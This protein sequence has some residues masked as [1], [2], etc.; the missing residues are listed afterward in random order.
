MPRRS[1]GV[2]WGVEARVGVGWGVL[3]SSMFD[4][5][6][7]LSSLAKLLTSSEHSLA[8]ASAWTHFWTQQRQRV[9]G[10]GGSGAGVP[11]GTHTLSVRVLHCTAW[12]KV[13]PYVCFV[14][15][16]GSPPPTTHHQSL[17]L[18]RCGIQPGSPGCWHRPHSGLGH[19][20]LAV[21]PL[22]PLRSLQAAISSEGYQGGCQLLW[23][24]EWIGGIWFGDV[25]WNRKLCHVFL[26]FFFSC[27]SCW[28]FFSPQYFR[29]RI[30]N[31]MDLHQYIS[32]CELWTYP[33]SQICFA[34]R[35]KDPL[36]LIS[37]WWRAEFS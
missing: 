24:H 29:N 5:L 11:A 14:R 12:P 32:L 4:P 36:K 22:T 13:N 8:V 17:G 19:W 30:N 1:R 27:P 37:L 28:F 34:G 10:G 31:S 25:L 2:G 35:S 26:S 6:F 23:I 3:S 9:R 33:R 16:E 21:W 20:D 7:M 15:W 18:S